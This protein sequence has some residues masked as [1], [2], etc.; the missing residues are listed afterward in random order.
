MASVEIY[1]NQY[2]HY[3]GN[4]CSALIHAP[5]PEGRGKYCTLH[6]L[7]L[8]RHGKKGLKHSA[9]FV[10]HTLP[11]SCIQ[12]SQT[13]VRLSPKRG[14]TP[15]TQNLKIARKLCKEKN[16]MTVLYKCQNACNACQSE[17]LFFILVFVLLTGALRSVPLQPVWK[18]HRDETHREKYLQCDSSSHFQYLLFKTD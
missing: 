16:R 10:L 12:S 9:T 17:L 14:K 4:Y 3:R 2:C 1:W 18:K 13:N 15:K 6:F 8:L 7:A 5:T 11:S